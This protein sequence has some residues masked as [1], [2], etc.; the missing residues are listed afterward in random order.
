[1]N[2][3]E[4][5]VSKSDKNCDPLR[6]NCDQVGRDTRRD[7]LKNWFCVNEKS[8]QMYNGDED[9][10]P[11]RTIRQKKQG[12]KNCM[13]EKEGKNGMYAQLQDPKTTAKASRNCSTTGPQPNTPWNAHHVE[14]QRGRHTTM[15]DAETE[16][17]DRRKGEMQKRKKMN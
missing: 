4:K 7:T 14:T 17:P 11:E 10:E 1:M 16:H 9:Q 13:K 5:I 12:D 15:Q 8:E 6:K 2:K 3:S